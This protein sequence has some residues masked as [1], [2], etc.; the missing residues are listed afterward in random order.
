MSRMSPFKNA[1]TAGTSRS[2]RV[3]RLGRKERPWLRCMVD[4]PR[5]NGLAF[6]FSAKVVP[7]R[8]AGGNGGG[9]SA[10]QFH[11]NR[12]NARLIVE[13]PCSVPKLREDGGGRPR[14]HV[15]LSTALQE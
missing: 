1:V 6:P 15:M 7:P 12:K 5:R 14:Y 13:C 10:C 11:C 8:L 2:S 4:F 9:K 3:S